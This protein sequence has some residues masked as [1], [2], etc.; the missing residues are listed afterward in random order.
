MENIGILY[1]YKLYYNL[2]LMLR[3]NCFL[4]IQVQKG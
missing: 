3:I 4:S 2:Y 1:T